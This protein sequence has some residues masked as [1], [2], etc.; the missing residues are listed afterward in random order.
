[1]LFYFRGKSI[2]FRNPQEMFYNIQL[3]INHFQPEIVPPSEIRTEHRRHR[4]CHRSRQNSKESSKSS[5]SHLK[6]TSLT[7]A[8]FK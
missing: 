5:Q 2:F 7:C 1:M 4:H 8:S 6:F 3:K